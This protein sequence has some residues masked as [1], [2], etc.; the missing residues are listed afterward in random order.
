[1]PIKI[2]ILDDHQIVI[3]GLKLLLKGHP[4]LNVVAENTNGLLLLENLKDIKVD[5]LLT[6]IMMPVMISLK[7]K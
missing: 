4:N 5:I 7:L 2:A 3:D 6:D 1:M